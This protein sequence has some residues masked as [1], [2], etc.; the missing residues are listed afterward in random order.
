MVIS[1]DAG[2]FTAFMSSI[3]EQEAFVYGVA[4]VVFIMIFMVVFDIPYLLHDYFRS[5]EIAAFCVARHVGDLAAPCKVSTCP[6]RNVCPYFKKRSYLRWLQEKL[7]K[8][9]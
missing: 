9:K 6:H 7:N 3:M 4:W 8:R 1:V 5:R 2:E